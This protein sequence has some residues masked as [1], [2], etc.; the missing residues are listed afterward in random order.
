LTLNDILLIQHLLKLI[1]KIFEFQKG[2]KKQNYFPLGEKYAEIYKLKL[3][4]DWHSII[5]PKKSG[6]KF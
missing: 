5:S 2:L 6:F 3:E 1:L 4:D